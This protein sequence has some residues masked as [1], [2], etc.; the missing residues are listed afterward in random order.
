MTFASGAMHLGAHHPVLAVG[1]G[2]DRARQRSEEARPARS[3]VELRFGFEERLAATGAAENAAAMLVV[4]WA[5]PG[6][7]GAVLAQHI[8]L[9]RRECD[10]PLFFCL[11]NVHTSILFRNQFS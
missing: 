8:K 9:F 3:A 11:R 4:Q 10:P 2:F 7:F 5:R 6:A 1:R